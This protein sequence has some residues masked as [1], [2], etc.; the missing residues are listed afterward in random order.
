MAVPTAIGCQAP[1]V[2]NGKVHNPQSTYRAGETL[3]FDCHPGYAAEGSDEARCQ[4]GG[5][6]NPPELVCQRGECG[7]CRSPGA[8]LPGRTRAAGRDFTHP[9]SITQAAFPLLPFSR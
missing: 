2:Q 7:C 8:A 9:C 5:I 6:W 4:P 1:E 3:H